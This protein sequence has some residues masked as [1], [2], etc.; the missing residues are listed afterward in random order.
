VVVQSSQQQGLKARVERKVVDGERSDGV[1]NM[2]ANTKLF[3]A[4]AIGISIGSIAQ[5]MMTVDST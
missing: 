1:L 4:I 3:P 2:A 5:Q